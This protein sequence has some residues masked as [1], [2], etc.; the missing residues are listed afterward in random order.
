MGQLD[1][2]GGRFDSLNKLG[3]LLLISDAID[4]T[5]KL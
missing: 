3:R 2:S 5:C 1:G 4:R